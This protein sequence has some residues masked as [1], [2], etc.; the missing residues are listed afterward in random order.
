MVHLVD[1]DLEMRR[2]LAF[3]LQS[4]GIVVLTYPHAASF[5]EEFDE[6]EPAVLILESRMRGLG[7]LQLQEELARREYPA[8][9][10]FCSAYG[11]ISIAVRAMRF[12]AVDFI[13]KPYD[14][15]RML[16]AVQAQVI[17]AQKVFA[18]RSERRTVMARLSG[19]TPRERDV[20]RLVIEGLPSQQIASK[21][22]A[23]VRT[24]D[25]H[26]ARIRSKTEAPSLGCLVRDVLL[27]DV[28]I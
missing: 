6:E 27:H 2:S 11:D 3:L 5:L 12:G 26:R 16:E 10:I 19:L 22:G 24:I 13:E 14:P 17:T 15:Q 20:L 7:G 8:P 9:I 23:N 28:E 25:V 21:L 18:E 1:D 4:V